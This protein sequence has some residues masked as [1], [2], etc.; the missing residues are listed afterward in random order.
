MT[1][2]VLSLHAECL[3]AKNICPFLRI[4]LFVQPSNVLLEKPLLYFYCLFVRY[5]YG[6][7][8]ICLVLFLLCNKDDQ[9]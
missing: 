8:S 9:T 3:T 2:Y 7:Y 1:D 5:L 4:V 6:I